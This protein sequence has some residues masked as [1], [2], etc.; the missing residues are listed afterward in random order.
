MDNK[1]YDINVKDL[2]IIKQFIE[3]GR[4]EELFNE[5]ERVHVN[6]VYDKLNYI[7]QKVT[8]KYN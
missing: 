2:V 1:D 7:I 4:R 6:S 8:Q 5:Q 3:K